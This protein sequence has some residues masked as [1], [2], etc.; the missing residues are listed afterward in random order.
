MRVAM[1]MIKRSN[2]RRILAAFGLIFQAVAVAQAQ[3]DDDL[4]RRVPSS[5]NVVVRVHVQPILDSVIGRREEWA[6]KQEAKTRA[7]LAIPTDARTLVFASKVDWTNQLKS[8]WDIGMVSS[9]QENS[10]ASIAKLDGGYVDT[11]E[12][13][14][15]A[16]L[17]RNAYVA[18]IAPQALAI[19]FPANRQ[20][21][22]QW[23]STT[24]TRKSAALSTYLGNAFRDEA[25]AH[26]VLACDTSNLLAIPQV[27]SRLRDSVS[28]REKEVDLEAYANILASLRGITLVAN[29]NSAVDTKLQADFALDASPIRQYGRQ[30]ILEALEEQGIS[31]PEMREW[32]MSVVGK[33]VRL[34]GRLGLNSL[35]LLAGFVAIPTSTVPNGKEVPPDPSQFDK[36]LTAEKASKKYYDEVVRMID[37]LR[38]KARGNQGYHM[39]VWVDRYALQIDRLPILNVDEDMLEYG[40]FVSS[41]LRS[42]RNVNMQTRANQRYT[43]AT[44][45][46]NSGAGY[47]YYN[48]IEANATMLR[49]QADAMISVNVN[50]IWTVLETK[51]A[52][53][54]RKETQKYET[55]F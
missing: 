55:E 3:T 24:N 21:L 28:L 12:G 34:E 36:Q 13:V 50:N 31:L 43:Q 15:T 46:A 54:R 44:N 30:L 41:A 1:N 40:T 18:S 33:S 25:R 29:F 35:P 47:G 48:D 26:Y 16:Y 10:V 23:L 38:S 20:E 7:G 32:R 2:I 17:P 11:V 42:V 49:R 14:E 8:A 27:K 5:A 39:S 4:I 22:A 19:M 45:S 51:T 9:S 52:E 37:D 53:I 6:A